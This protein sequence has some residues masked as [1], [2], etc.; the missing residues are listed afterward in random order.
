MV[1]VMEDMVEDMDMV[2]I[3]AMVIVGAIVITEA[4]VIVATLEEDTVAVGTVDIVVDRKKVT[5]NK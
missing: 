1:M 4:I 5:Q 2:I 3:E